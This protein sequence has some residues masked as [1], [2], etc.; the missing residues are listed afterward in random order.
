MARVTLY[1]TDKMKAEMEKTN[2][3]WSKIFQGVVATTLTEGKKQSGRSRFFDVTV[4]GK[5]GNRDPERFVGATEPTSRK[6]VRFIGWHCLK[7]HHITK[8]EEK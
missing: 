8:L 6:S 5:C 7:C 2:D 1:V 3:N 4:C